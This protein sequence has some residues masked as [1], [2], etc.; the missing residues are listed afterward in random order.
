MKLLLDGKSFADKK[1]VHA[2]LKKEL[3]FPEYY[4][5]NLDAFYD[6]LCDIDFPVEFE[7][8]NMEAY[9]GFSDCIIDAMK[10]NNNLSI[11]K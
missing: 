10:I 2:Y 6:L 5:N 1:A 7:L 8:I 9:Q 3:S 4:G 11:K